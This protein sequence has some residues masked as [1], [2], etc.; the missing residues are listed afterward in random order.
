ME[1]QFREWQR[2]KWKLDKRAYR[3]KKKA[4]KAKVTE[5]WVSEQITFNFQ[6]V[7]LANLKAAHIAGINAE[8]IFGKKEAIGK[9]MKANMHNNGLKQANN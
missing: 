6:N 3:A 1:E 4:E 2:D 7:K 9:W 8:L 5:P